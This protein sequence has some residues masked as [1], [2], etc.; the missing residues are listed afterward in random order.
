MRSAPSRLVRINLVTAAPGD[1]PDGQKLRQHWYQ[2]SG[3]HFIMPSVDANL[4][5]PDLYRFLDAHGIHRHNE[6]G[7]SASP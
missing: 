6:H 7:L 2:G 1:L 5:Y 3:D 4:W